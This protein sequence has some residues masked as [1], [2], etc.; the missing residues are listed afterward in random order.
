MNSIQI[1]FTP[2][3]GNNNP[4]WEIVIPTTMSRNWIEITYTIDGVT[5]EVKKREERRLIEF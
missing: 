3:N 5:G 4:Y 1:I 2:R